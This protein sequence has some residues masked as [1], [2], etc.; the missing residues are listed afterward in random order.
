MGSRGSRFNPLHPQGE[1]IHKFRESCIIST[2]LSDRVKN[3]LK[4]CATLNTLA[5]PE[6]SISSPTI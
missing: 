3:E 1:S 4:P 6:M 5:K 2:L